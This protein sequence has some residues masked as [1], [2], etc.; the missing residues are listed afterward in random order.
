MKGGPVPRCR[1]ADGAG[2]V[3]RARRPGGPARA[4]ARAA[5]LLAAWAL[6]GCSNRADVLAVVGTRPITMAEFNDVAR[7]SLRQYPGSP[8]S[9]RARLLADMVQRRLLV[10]GA[11]A[12]HLDGTPAFIAFR[13]TLERQL[14]REALFQR[15]AGGPFGVSEAEARTLYERRRTA[16][17]LRLIFTYTE[18]VAKHAAMDIARGLDFATVANRYN[19]SGMVPAGGD[20][21][22]VQAGALMPPLDEI[23]RTGPLD[24]LIGPIGVR[25]QG[26][27]VLR[28]D[29]RKPATD[30]PYEQERAQLMEALRQRK[31]RVTAL[32]LIENLRE[33]YQVQVVPGAPQAMV[34]QFRTGGSVASVA[35]LGPAR[36]QVL[37]TYL[38]GR[39]TL[40]EAYDDLA[41]ESAGR[42]NLDATP[43]VERWIE[44]QAVNQAAVAEAT[45]RR[46][47]DEPELK[48][49]MRDRLDNFLLDAYY[50]RQVMQRIAVGPADVAMAYDHYKSGFLQLTKARV[51]SVTLKDSAA[52]AELAAHA[53]QAPS[54][55]EA[56]AAAGAGAHVREESLTFPNATDWGAFAAKL[57]TMHAGEIAGP[58]AT[59]AGWRI[60][61]LIEST[62]AAPPLESLSPGAVQQLQNVATEIKRESRLAALTD[63]LR[64]A[65]R[66]VFLYADR[67][68]RVPWPPAPATPGS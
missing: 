31:Q 68:R 47:Q 9:A 30:A 21:G 59:P 8:D 37:A 15:L 18:E 46:L 48:Q 20:V 64:H 65:V 13:G 58:Y 23:V 67:L 32:R 61:Q 52:A 55:R 39:Y 19:P 16:T 28:L 45:T 36:D 42:P 51:Q 66:P 35:P 50:T 11:I 7:V 57:A 33:L 22:L 17:H 44:A 54:L 14:L 41:S 62:V 1:V 3:A 5:L 27:F 26:W 56:A 12:E 43:V 2:D 34:S 49:R 63:S 24:T 29:A 60:V 40:G 53:G 10:E 4:L 25:G 38:G 6:A